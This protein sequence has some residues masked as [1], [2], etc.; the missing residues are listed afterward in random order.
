VAEDTVNK[1]YRPIPAG[2][3]S[4]KQARQRWWTSWTLGPVVL[5]ALFGPWAAIHLVI[6][7]AWTAFCYVWPKPN[8][9]F[10][11]NAFTAVGIITLL[12]IL[13]AVIC[14]FAPEWD[15]SIRPDLVLS[16][17]ITFTIHLQEFHDVEGDR[18]SKRRTLPVVLTSGAVVKLRLVTACILVGSSY[19]DLFW[20]WAY[21]NSG[22]RR[23]PWVTG[24]AHHM[25]AVVV[26]V[27][28]VRS[29]SKDMDKTTY[30][31]YYI[32]AAFCVDNPSGTVES[33]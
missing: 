11:R 24:F 27:R 4:V 17:W 12:R 20:T 2:L 9:W 19:L 25:A 28:T 13:N 10:F 18:R 6:W 3:L 30:H 29:T 8:H 7:E 16:V 31:C 22:Q 21:C 33:F 14:D 23:G 5:Y 26:A 1:P 32:T 15:M